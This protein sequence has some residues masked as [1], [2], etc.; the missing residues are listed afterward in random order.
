MIEY[1][2]QTIFILCPV[3]R[4]N[5]QTHSPTQKYTK[6]MA[7]RMWIITKLYPGYSLAMSYVSKIY[8]GIIWLWLIYAIPY[9]GMVW[10][11]LMYTK[12]YSGYSLA[13]IYICQTIPQVTYVWFGGYTGWKCDTFAIQ[14]N[15]ILKWNIGTFRVVL[16]SPNWIFWIALLKM[17]EHSQ[18]WL[19]SLYWDWIVAVEAAG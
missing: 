16:I 6:G 19:T 15:W 18:V 1:T 2:T 17:E 4:C 3:N 7:W 10:L 14:K 5:R 9:P 8:L 11:W 13:T 12:P